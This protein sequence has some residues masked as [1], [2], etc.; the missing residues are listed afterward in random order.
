MMRILYLTLPALMD[1]SLSFAQAAA[2]RAELHLC[3]QIPPDGWHSSL[4]DVHPAPPGSD[5][6]P[7]ATLLSGYPPALAGFW[8]GTASFQAAVF[9]G[10]SALHPASWPGARAVLR[11]ARRLRPDVIHLETT[12]GRLVGILPALHRLA[13]LVLTV[14]DPQP[15][16]GEAP[17]KKRLI[18]VLTYAWADHFILHNQAQQAAFCRRQRINPER[19]SVTPLGVYHLY[20]CFSRTTP[21]SDPHTILFFGRLS[22]YKGLETL[23]AAA[24]AACLQIPRLRFVIAGR[25]GPGYRLPPLPA[26]P[27]GGQLEVIADYIPN[28]RLASL[29]QQAGLVVCPYTDATQSGVVLTAYAFGRPVLATRVGGLPEYITPGRTGWL[30]PPGDPAALAE[31]L[32]QAVLALRSDPAA[33][34]QAITDRSL[35]DLNWEAIAAQTLAIYQR[36]CPE[37]TA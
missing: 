14:H 6:I 4:F 13:P 16:S 30:V 7:A 29:F 34:R 31:G 35:A 19:V 23:L 32:V 11:L 33:F 8:R 27:N 24:P 3:L 12:L 21:L 1:A 26:L 9:G 5:L 28:D 25:P 36:V 2:A 20:R 15:H 22:R 37:V 17:L 10:G 18:R